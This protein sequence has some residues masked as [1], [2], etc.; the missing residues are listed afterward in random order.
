[1]S[2]IHRQPGKPCWFCAYYDPEG[3]RRFRSAG[4]GNRAVASA[5]CTAIE[6][7]SR[8]ARENKLSNEKAQS[9]IREIKASVAENPKH[10]PLVADTAEK[11][12][13][14]IVEEFVR[15]AGGELTTFTVKLWLDTWLAGKTDASKATKIEYKRIVDLF[16][17]FLGARADRPLSTVQPVHVEQ[18]KAHLAGR[19][20]PSTINKCVK[21]LKGAFGSAVA[22]RQLEFS[23]AEHV[24]FNE[25]AASKRR[26]FTLA[27]IKSLL[28]VAEGDWR[29]MVLLGLYSGQRL[30]DC[31]SLTWREVDLLQSFISLQTQKT[32]REQVI[33]I[34]EPLAKHLATL[35]GD[36][37]DAPLCPTL[38]GKPSSALSG[39]FYAV[40]VKAGLAQPR[41][42]ASTGKGRDGKRD[43]NRVSFHSL[44]HSAT[45]L[46]KSAGASDSVVMDLIGHES[47][48]VSRVYTHIAD[49]A[50]RAAVNKLPDV[51]N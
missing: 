19:V 37:P 15:M 46:M 25:A 24:E 27:E 10:G 9:L 14:P 51:V 44:R 13:R 47:E 16:A 34:A 5:I 8:L 41:D 39:Q 33:P 3:F 12:L 38:H 49:D 32:G 36:D 4:T 48:A 23:P 43:L 7:A 26:A 35:A 40:M 28:T 31:A 22:K 30:Q 2:S 29:T 11:T 6:R 21:V 42:H 20:A 1:M 50:K 17:K 18:F 45:S